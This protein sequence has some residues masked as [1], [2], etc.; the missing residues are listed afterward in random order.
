MIKILKITEFSNAAVN[1]KMINKD[2]SLQI[3]LKLS[4]WVSESSLKII[5]TCIIAEGF[6]NDNNSILDKCSSNIFKHLT[7]QA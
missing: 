4:L 1:N 2:L 6:P 7:L 5:T 3:K